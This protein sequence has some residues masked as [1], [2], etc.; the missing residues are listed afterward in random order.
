MK[1]SDRNALVANNSVAMSEL[2]SPLAA[3]EKYREHSQG[4]ITAKDM[5]IVDARAVE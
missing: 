3:T 2:R 5:S 1:E 4:L